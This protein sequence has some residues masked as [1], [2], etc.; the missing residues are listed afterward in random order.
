MIF[1]KETKNKISK[2]Q[3]IYEEV[4]MWENLHVI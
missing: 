3:K 4:M 2:Q 1:F